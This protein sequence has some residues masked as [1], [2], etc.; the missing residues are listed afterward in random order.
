MIWAQKGA[1]IFFISE[2][3]RAGHFS[4]PAQGL[5]YTGNTKSSCGSYALLEE[6]VLLCGAGR[7][8]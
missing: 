3:Y 4:C 5:L 1:Q 8:G 6:I 7:E 2:E